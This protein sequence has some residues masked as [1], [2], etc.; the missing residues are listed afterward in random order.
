MLAI[1]A[2]RLGA[3]DGLGGDGEEVRGMTLSGGGMVLH[4]VFKQRED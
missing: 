3:E 2:F 1:M 4:F